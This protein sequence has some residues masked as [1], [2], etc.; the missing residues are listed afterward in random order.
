MVRADRL[1]VERGLARSRTLARRLIESGSVSAFD[2]SGR[3][4]PLKPSTELA[5]D[6]RIDVAASELDAYVSRGGLKLAAALRDF[7]I[8]VRGRHCLDVGQSTGGFTD[9]LLQQGAAF[10]CGIDVGHDQLDPSLRDRPD[11]RAI[12]RT[13]VRYLGRDELARLCPE[14]LARPFELVV[15]DLSFIS[16]RLVL[17]ALAALVDPG[18]PLVA[19]VKP[20]FEAGREALDARG[21]VRSDAAIEGVRETVGAA[22]HAT[23]W[24]VLAWTRS[25]IEGGDGNRELFLHARREPAPSALHDEGVRTGSPA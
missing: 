2:P 20:Q 3:P 1:I 9:C 25:P 17:P 24:S 23:G 4:V 19:L 14:S 6:A 18:C 12:E 8:D 10:V 5:P 16:L 11:V 7:G 21:I 22:A 13:N 15:A